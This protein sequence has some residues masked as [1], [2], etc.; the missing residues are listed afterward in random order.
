MLLTFPELNNSILLISEVEMSPLNTSDWDSG[1]ITL[2]AF[3]DDKII[4]N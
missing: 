3:G 1:L 2:S 4:R